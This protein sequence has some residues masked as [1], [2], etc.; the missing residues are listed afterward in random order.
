MEKLIQQVNF[1]QP[2]FQKVRE[3]FNVAVM[4]G[5]LVA[6]AVIMAAATAYV[7]Y[8][9]HVLEHRITSLQ[10]E[11]QHLQNQVYVIREKLKPRTTNRLLVT[12]KDSL[13]DDLASAHR[14]SHLLSSNIDEQ[15][16]SYSAYFR[17][18]AESSLDGLWLKSLHI[19]QG[20]ESLKISGHAIR[21]E[22]V[23]RLLQRLKKQQVFDGHSFENV[24]MA[25]PK[26]DGLQKAIMF[27]LETVS[28]SEESQ[29]AG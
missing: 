14:L 15:T 27:E 22:L 18:L 3:P 4:G 29:D 21:P 23:P 11:Q 17:G 24:L 2:I 6:A 1:Y 20:G 7:I 9:K 10:N 13:N 25:R 16:G 19:N 12:K 5:I 26:E 28:F 8:Q